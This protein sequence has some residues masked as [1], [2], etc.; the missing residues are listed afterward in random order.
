[1]VVE[2][3]YR[4]SHKEALLLCHCEGGS[5][6]KTFTGLLHWIANGADRL[7]DYRGGCLIV[8]VALSLYVVYESTII[9][10]EKGY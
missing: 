9:M 4:V 7:T 5:K 8:S 3:K 6:F 1:M 2:Y 10:W